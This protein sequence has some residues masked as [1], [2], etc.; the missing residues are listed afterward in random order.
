[1]ND[2][3]L[4]IGWFAILFAL[5]FGAAYF[6]AKRKIG[7]RRGPFWV[8]PDTAIRL[9][10]PSGSFRSRFLQATKEGWMIAAPVQRDAFVPLRI[11]EGLVV[12]APGA[13]GVW[14]FRT[15]VLDRQLEGHLLVLSRPEHPHLIDR[16][17]QPRDVDVRG[18]CVELNGCESEL[19]D[20]SAGGAR[21][22]TDAPLANG[23]NILM[24]LHADLGEARGWALECAP[25]RNGEGKRAVRV[26]FSEPMAAL[27]TKKKL[28]RN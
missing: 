6:L 7:I 18:A 26:C 23:D 14:T 1:M 9:S 17:S 21:V 20:I 2:I 5:S 4:L 3:A 8:D 25:V 11:G 16:R 19:L 24:M 15:K 10:S 13:G 12:Q 28:P 22:L 27:Q